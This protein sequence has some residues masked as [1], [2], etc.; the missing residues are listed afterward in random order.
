MFRTVLFSRAWLLVPFVFRR[1]GK[2]CVAMLK[3]IENPNVCEKKAQVALWS[4][5]FSCCFASRE[6]AE[7]QWIYT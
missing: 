4:V 2:L 6:D 3:D 7:V 5:A 1:I